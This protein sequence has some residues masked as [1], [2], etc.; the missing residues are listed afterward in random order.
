MRSFLQAFEAN[1][2]TP[3]TN[4]SEFLSDDDLNTK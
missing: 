2:L 1:N 4:T 3:D